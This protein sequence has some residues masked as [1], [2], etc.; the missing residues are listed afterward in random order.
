MCADGLLVGNNE[1]GFLEADVRALCDVARSTKLD[2]AGVS[3]APRIGCKGIGFKSVF[4]LS[5]T[6]HIVS[7][8]FHIYFDAQHPSGLGLLVPLWMDA[9]RRSAMPECALPAA[10]AGAL[11]PSDAWGT[12]LWLPLRDEHK[13]E[14]ERMV[15]RLVAT[16]RPHLLLFLNQLTTVSIRNTLTGLDAQLHRR[17]LPNHVVEVLISREPQPMDTA[18][19]AALDTMPTQ[20]SYR[21]LLH[22]HAVDTHG[23]SKH[24][25][26]SGAPGAAS[27]STL[28]LAMPITWPGKRADGTA[29]TQAPQ[30][31]VYAFLPLCSYGLRFALHA[32]WVIP[33]AR[34][35]ISTGSPWNEL[36]RDSVP[37][38]FTQ[39]VLSTRA[40]PEL[41]SLW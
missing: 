11:E 31:F 40:S 8:S 33:S 21:W 16:V 32:D 41:R 19:S 37:D 26:A 5:D 29:D 18:S 30:Q 27:H 17:Q 24:A 25:A 35:A 34:E 1:Q 14:W 28:K 39:L 3:K 15:G 38:A 23:I 4:A 9:Q 12:R 7:S 20:G 10:P 6:P 13:A 2:T 36:L 22:A